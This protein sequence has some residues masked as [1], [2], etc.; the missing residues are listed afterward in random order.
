M[1]PAV[2]HRAEVERLQ[3]YLSDIRFQ[4]PAHRRGDAVVVRIKP[5]YLAQNADFAVHQREKFVKS[6][7]GVFGAFEAHGLKFLKR[8]LGYF[9]VGAANAFQVVVVKYDK[10]PVGGKVHVYLDGETVLDRRPEGGHAVFRFVAV[11]QTAVRD[12]GG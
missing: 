4:S 7:N 10:V 6:R 1:T 8:A 9:F 2:T 5:F 12:R 11:V 3:S